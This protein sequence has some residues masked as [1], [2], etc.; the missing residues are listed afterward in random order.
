MAETPLRVSKELAE[1][2]GNTLSML[3]DV[4]LKL[5]DGLKK[6]DLDHIRADILRS[7][8][9]ASSISTHRLTQLANICGCIDNLNKITNTTTIPQ[10]YQDKLHLLKEI[11]DTLEYGLH[12]F[13]GIH[14]VGSHTNFTLEH[15]V[16]KHK[17]DIQNMA[18]QIIQDMPT[19]VRADSQKKLDEI[20]KGG[21]GQDIEL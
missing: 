9:E 10:A 11:F 15:L 12:S 20:I 3:Q 17:K 14:N 6:S 5:V 7:R 21:E 18:Q 4:A 1:H 2:L 8:D 13:H 19:M 16:K